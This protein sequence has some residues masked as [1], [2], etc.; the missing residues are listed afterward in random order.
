MDIHGDVTIDLNE[1][2]YDGQIVLGAPTFR[3][4]SALQNAIVKLAGM[5]DGK[6]VLANV[7]LGDMNLL[8]NLAYVK[9]APFYTGFDKGLEPLMEFMDE[10]DKKEVGSAQKL[11]DAIEVNVGRIIKGETHPLQ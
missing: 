11:W 3:R 10:L 8:T 9:S 5:D 1:F 7:P 4:T 6:P 2:G